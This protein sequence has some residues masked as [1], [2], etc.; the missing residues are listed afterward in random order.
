MIENDEFRE[1]IARIVREEI[2]VIA[3]ET[4]N[5]IAE[6][7]RTELIPGLRAAI[8]ESI[9]K[10]LGCAV[11]GRQFASDGCATFEGRSKEEIETAVSSGALPPQK[12]TSEVVEETID[13]GD[14]QGLYLYGLTDTSVS[15]SLGKIGIDECE[16]YTIPYD[17][18]S[19]IIHNSPLEPYKSDNNETVK[20]WVKVHQRVMDVAAERFGNVMPFGF[21]TIISPKDNATAKD[22]LMR[23]LSDEHEEILRQMDKIKGKKEYGIQIFYIPSAFGE[24]IE[25]ESDEVKRMKEQMASKPPGLAYMYKQKLENIVKGELDTLMDAYFKNFYEKIKGASDEIKVEKVKKADDCMVMMMNLSVLA[26]D[27]KALGSVLDEIESE[28][29]IKIHFTGPWQPYSFI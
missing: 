16:V 7:V 18:I 10:E 3:Q 24:K 13:A 4:N 8:R 1:L 15:A 6:I 21:D 17:G 27:E 19:A 11:S 5:I 22:E 14:D 29:G 12:A 9:A 20:V 23:W 2:K 25:K 28:E 26:R